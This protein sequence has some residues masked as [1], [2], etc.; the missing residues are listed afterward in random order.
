AGRRAQGAYFTPPPL[1]DLVVREALAARLRRRPVAWRADG[2]PELVV[3]DPA[4]GDGR[5]LSAAA[6]LLADKAARRGVGRAD[7]RG[8]IARRCLIGIERDP[9]FAALARARLGPGARVHCAEALLSDLIPPG[10]AD[11]VIGNPPY[12]RSIRLGESDE[13]LRRALRGRYAA[14]SRG[15]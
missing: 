12:V 15:E 9:E 2:S 13:P 8:A 5:F 3:L 11:L 1:V 14:T 10:S 7:A 4:A 6:D